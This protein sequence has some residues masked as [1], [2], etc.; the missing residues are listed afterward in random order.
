MLC[1]ELQAVPKINSKW[2]N[3]ELLLAVQGNLYSFISLLPQR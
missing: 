1:F 2:T 3:E